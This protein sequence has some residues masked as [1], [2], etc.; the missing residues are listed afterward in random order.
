VFAITTAKGSNWDCQVRSMFSEDPW[1][2]NLVLPCG[3]T[4]GG[5]DP[6]GLSASA[7]RSGSEGSDNRR[8]FSRR[9]C[10]VAGVWVPTNAG[11]EPR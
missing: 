8:H 6:S 11:S 10:Q 7:D 3:S 5:P 4:V 1:A 9:L 2:T